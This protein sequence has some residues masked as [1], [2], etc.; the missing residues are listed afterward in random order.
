[1]N[2]RRT[3]T[4]MLLCAFC[5]PAQ[6]LDLSHLDRLDEKA[7]ERVNVNLN[8]DLLQA[9]GKLLSPSDPDQARVKTLVG[10][11][12]SVHVRA[13]E[14]DQAGAYTQNDVE[15]IRR[16]L[17]APGWHR[18]VDVRSK[19]EGENVDIYLHMAGEK[20]DGVAVLAAEPRELTV[21]NIVGPINLEDLG[22]LGGQFGIPKLPPGQKAEP[23]S[24]RKSN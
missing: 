19:D 9:A 4:L 20:V 14:F 17:R 11:L 5:L 3:C 2:K 18:I 12:E 7:K 1:M 16:E 13:F 10:K 15:A 22:A 21:V 8:R 23:K 24:D 6:R